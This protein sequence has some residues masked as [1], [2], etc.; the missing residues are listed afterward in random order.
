MRTPHLVLLHPPGVYDFRQEAILCGPLA[1]FAS[2]PLALERVALS[3]AGLAGQLGRSGLRVETM[4]LARCM[5]EAPTFDVETAL[6]AVEPLAFVISFHW[7]AQVQGVLA[8]ALLIKTFHPDTPVVLAG[9]AADYF[10]RELIAYPQVDYV[11]RGPAIAAP[12]TVLVNVLSSGRLPTTVAGLTWRAT[13]GDVIENPPLLDT[14]ERSCDASLAADVQGWTG[15]LPLARLDGA[16]RPVP[17]TGQGCTQ[18]CVVCNNSLYARRRLYGCSTPHYRPPE[19]VVGELYGNRHRGHTAVYLVGDVSQAAPDYLS[20]FLRGARGFPDL[21]SFDV[22]Q[23]IPRRLLSDIITALPY[24][25]LEMLMYSPLPEIRQ[26]AG[27]Y[28]SNAAIEQTISDALALGYARVRLYFVIGLPHQSASAA[29][30]AVEYADELLTRFE[31]DRR[32]QPLVTPLVPFLEPGSLAFEDS[33]RLGVRRCCGTVEEHRR[34]RLAPSWKHALNYH[35]THMTRDDLA[36]VTYEITAAMARVRGKHNLLSG[37]QVAEVEQ[38]VSL[39]RRLMDDIDNL[40]R[41]EDPER[42][43]DRLSHLKPQIDAANLAAMQCRDF[44][45][46]PSSATM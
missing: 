26:A 28:Y 33:D 17:L 25:A 46:P 6:A 44:L 23:P 13:N 34:A 4:N 12:L 35:T 9:Q 14:D 8:I 21:V 39:T 32:L 42:I 7:L 31:G 16:V 20:R 10:H 27:R 3:H 29:C 1:D 15:C 37:Q 19:Q 2:S 24:C 30:D 5:L 18:N 38:T 22:F 11:V 43:Q 40:V 45:S 36:R 41:E